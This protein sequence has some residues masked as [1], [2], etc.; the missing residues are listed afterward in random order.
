MVDGLL[1]HEEALGDLAVAETLSDEPEHLDLSGRQAGWVLLGRSARASR[2]PSDAALAQATGDDPRRRLRTE[3]L[4]LARGPGEARRPRRCPQAQG[5]PRTDSPASSTAP[6]RAPAHRPAPAR[7]ARARIREP[8]R[9]C[10]PDGARLR[11]HRSPTQ[12]AFAARARKW[13]R[14]RPRSDRAR[15]RARQLRPS[16][17][18]RARRVAAPHWSRQAREPR[19]AEALPLDLRGA[20]GRGRAP[21]ARGSTG[22]KRPEGCRG[23]VS[24]RQRRRP[25]AR[26]RGRL[27]PDT[28]AGRATKDRDPARSRSRCRPSPDLPASTHGCGPLPSRS[29]GRPGPHGLPD[30]RGWRARG[31]GPGALHLRGLPRGVS[32]CR[33][34]SANTRV[35]RLRRVAPRAR[36]RASP[37]ASCP[38]RLRGSCR[39]TR[40]RRRRSRAHDPAEASRAPRRPRRSPDG[41]PHRRLRTRLVGRTS[42][43][44][45]PPCAG[46]RCPAE[47]R[48]PAVAPRQRRRTGR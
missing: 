30:P 33:R 18:R 5:Q 40:R 29:E 2:Q 13:R 12:S 28:R 45:H 17:R 42:R 35:P 14:S 22:G 20:S 4:E 37:T 21:R 7:R 9:G 43:A 16:P 46:R 6:R 1:S 24:P 41:L 19:R 8:L 26:G 38:R 32:W 11:A 34:C 3:F 44:P 31:C 23:R 36:S 10:P 15:R 48:R 27:G 47:G 25:S 39:S